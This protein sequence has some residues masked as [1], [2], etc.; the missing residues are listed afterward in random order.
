MNWEVVE[1]VSHTRVTKRTR[2]KI[3]DYYSF[4]N[5]QGH[6]GEEAWLY[7][8][9]LHRWVECEDGTKLKLTEEEYEVLN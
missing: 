3:L 5:L 2:V 4:G 9:G 7:D 8:N 6:Q 1:G